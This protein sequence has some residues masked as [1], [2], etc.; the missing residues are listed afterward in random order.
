MRYPRETALPIEIPIEVFDIP[1]HEIRR[2]YRSDVYF[3]RAKR[4]L[5][6]SQRREK[7]TIQVFQKQKAILCGIEEALA[8]VILGAG[9]YRNPTQAFKLFDRLIESKRQIRSLYRAGTDLL[10]NALREKDEI[11]Q[12]LDFE[13]VSNLDEIR[14][15]SLKD[16][17][18]IDP[19][20]TTLLIEGPLSE[21]I[22]LETLYLGVLARRTRIATNVS[23]VA[24]AANG[25]PV[26]FFPARFD[27]WAVQG[28]DGYAASV[29][30]A[31]SVSTDA[32]GEWW[33]MKGGGTIPHCLIAA[34]H[35]NTVDAT[36][37]FAETFPD[38]PLVALVDFENDCVRTSLEVAR[39]LG[40]QLWAVRLDT[41][42]QLVDVSLINNPSDQKQPGVT[43]E[44]VRN[45]RMALDK[46]GFSKVRIV[47]SGGFDVDKI[48]RFENTGVPVDAYGVG[49]A[50]MKGN[51]DFT[52]DAVKINDKPMAKVGRRYRAN[53]R[54]VE[55]S[56]TPA[57]TT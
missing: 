22:H 19:W 17:D 46:E 44:L 4:T 49:S 27:H 43:P 10:N 51:F 39:A 41:S 9:H 35:G 52:A 33:G 5:E 1:V 13:W 36:Q 16:G 20:E 6:E 56:L 23:A 14:V 50:F 18:A 54:L 40:N 12:A 11:I 29:G 45:V 28:G 38:T 32:Q 47:A 34:Y 55:R 57:K 48:L 3:W 25:K 30:G 7:A 21:F 2:G 8:I 15:Q 24:E 53:D 37:R 42:E 26:F 31:D